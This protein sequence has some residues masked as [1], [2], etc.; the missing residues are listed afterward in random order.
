MRSFSLLLLACLTALAAAWS[1]E[2][3]EIFRLRDEVATNE[4]HNVTFYSW[5]GIQPSASQAD[6]N[7]AY[8]KLSRSL[9]PDKAQSNWIASYNLPPRAKPGAKPT[10]HVHKN[11]KPSASEIA[12]FHK[13]ASARFERL[14]LIANVLRGPE[15]QRYDH[16]L[17]NGFPKWR[18]TGY[19]YERFRP[20]LGTV[21]F[22][23]FVFAGGAVHYAALYVSW[24]RQH[25][26]LDRYIR[27]ARRTAWGDEMF[28]SSGAIPGLGGSSSDAT[29]ATAS[30][31]TAA[32]GEGNDVAIAYNRKQKRA[33][34]KEKRK[35][36]KN[37]GKAASKAAAAEK[38][39]ARAAALSGAA[40]EELE[41]EEEYDDFPAVKPVGAK[42][43][44]VAENGKILIV[45]SV[46][47]VF[48]E[49]TTAEGV[50]QE[51]LLDTLQPN[52]VPKPTIN[53]TILMRL[54]LF[55]YNRTLGALIN[56]PT[57]GHLVKQLQNGGA[58][59]GQQDILVSAAVPE[60][61]AKA[62][63]EKAGKK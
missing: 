33:M 1:K 50:R 22:G 5:L 19:Y 44:T 63:K 3:H 39:K 29:T 48:L 30:S 58:D 32:A 36:A 54:P 57:T 11:K 38:Q 43:R 2:D 25:E 12:K 28:G 18:G 10:V 52:E 23:L 9:H 31:P 13:T 59:G 53:D 40:E 20:G 37:P 14:S 60:S 6:I 45:D 42:K 21:L 47:N 62:R 26:F 49:E 34:D 46:G 17:R 55:V 61:E 4:G 51:L 35:D 8:R 56:R 41:D 16:F 24:R 15:R 27:H 7:A